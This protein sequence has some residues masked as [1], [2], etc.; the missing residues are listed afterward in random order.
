MG[1]FDNVTETL[2]S[3]AGLTQGAGPG[4]INSVLAKSNFGDLQGLINQLQAGGLGEQ[5]QS[6]LSN[7]PNMPVSADQLRGALDNQQVR[8]LAER[9][10]LPVDATLELLAKHLPA[11]VDQASPNGT[12]AN[13]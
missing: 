12:L 8:Q 7:N 1:L 6:W 11:T 3:F 13:G 9:F 2:K 5:V 4:L 10:G